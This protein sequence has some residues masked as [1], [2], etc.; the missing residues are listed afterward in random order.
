LNGE[1]VVPAAVDAAIDAVNAAVAAGEAAQQR[2]ATRRALIVGGEADGGGFGL[3]VGR[4]GVLS[5]A[6]LEGSR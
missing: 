5:I 6:R 4:A 1:I 3:E 2:G